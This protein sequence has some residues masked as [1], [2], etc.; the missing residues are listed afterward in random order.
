[1]T[2]LRACA[3]QEEKGPGHRLPNFSLPY[4][5]LRKEL[6]IPVTLRNMDGLKKG[7]LADLEGALAA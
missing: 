2:T 4:S 5:W 7:E 3:E 1:M 6:N